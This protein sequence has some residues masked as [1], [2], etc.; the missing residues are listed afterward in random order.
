MKTK[1]SAEA[2]RRAEE[3][4]ARLSKAEP[5]GEALRALRAIEVLEHIGTPEASRVLETLAKGA[6][7]ARLTRDAKASLGR[8]ARRPLAKP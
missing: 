5:T 8:L 2:R 3:I 4:L 6:P 7:E 1:P